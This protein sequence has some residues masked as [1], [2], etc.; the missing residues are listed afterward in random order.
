MFVQDF[1]LATE[2]SR[3][4]SRSL[5]RRRGDLCE[6]D[7]LRDGVPSETESDEGVVEVESRRR[8]ANEA[9]R[10]KVEERKNCEQVYR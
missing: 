8:D 2:E 5:F 1:P 6:I 4:D 10:E 3:E 9:L 7:Q